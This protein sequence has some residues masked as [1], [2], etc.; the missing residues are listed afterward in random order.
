VLQVLSSK[1]RPAQKLQLLQDRVLVSCG[2]LLLRCWRGIVCVACCSATVQLHRSA[3]PLWVVLWRLWDQ[4]LLGERPGFC[5]GSREGS[6]EHFAVWRV[7]RS[8]TDCAARQR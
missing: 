4:D 2:Q 1:R 6:V 3:A 8:P 5:Q 7:I